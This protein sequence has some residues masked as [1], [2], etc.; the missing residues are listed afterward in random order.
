MD[1]LLGQCNFVHHDL[2][3]N[4]NH[5]KFLRRFKVENGSQCTVKLDCK[6]RQDKNQLGFKIQITKLTKLQWCSIE[7]LQ[8][9]FFKNLLL[10]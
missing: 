7:S 2:E 9:V 6:N 4:W 3:E 8:Q 1:R 10:F 5:C